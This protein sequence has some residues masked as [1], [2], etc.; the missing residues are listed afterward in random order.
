MC[1]NSVVCRASHGKVWLNVFE[2]RQLRFRWSER[3]FRLHWYSVPKP[4]RRG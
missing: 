3:W 2:V 1:L 4:H